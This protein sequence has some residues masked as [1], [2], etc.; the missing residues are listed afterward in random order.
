MR[1]RSL[2]LSIA[3]V[4]ATT[5]S[6]ALSPPPASTSAP[7]PGY[8]AD[9]TTPVP[10][11]NEKSGVLFNVVVKV[12][13]LEGVTCW[14]H[15]LTSKNSS[16]NDLSKLKKEEYDQTVNKHLPEVTKCVES[17]QDKL[18]EKMEGVVE[19]AEKLPPSLTQT[20]FQKQAEQ[21]VEQTFPNFA[22]DWEALEKNPLYSKIVPGTPTTD[23]NAE[24]E[25]ILSPKK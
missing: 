4:V 23:P 5:A 19:C 22:K 12:A 10:L 20:Q 14:N 16:W 2:V 11:S 15:V 25:L 17:R 8:A 3:A 1:T 24:S 7:T 9:A 21:C 6:W 13:L 18:E